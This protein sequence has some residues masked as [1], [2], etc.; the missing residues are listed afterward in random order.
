LGQESLFFVDFSRVVHIELNAQHHFF[1]LAALTRNS[2]STLQLL[3][4]SP[5]LR[6]RLGASRLIDLFDSSVGRDSISSMRSLDSD[7]SPHFGCTSYVLHNSALIFLRGNVTGANLTAIGFRECLDQTARKRS[8]VLDMRHVVA[9][10]TSALAD[11]YAACVSAAE[12]GGNVL[13]CGAGRR[14][15]QAM[16]VSGLDW[17]LKHIEDTDLMSWIIEE[18]ACV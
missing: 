4:I 16:K 13:A 12:G 11:L 6:R 10:D 2:D 5:R 14:I 18:S 15:R 8:C 1:R 9:L 17:P 7:D 3:G